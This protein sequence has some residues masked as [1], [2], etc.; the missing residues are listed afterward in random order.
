MLY[1]VGVVPCQLTKGENFIDNEFCH[2][3]VY[4]ASFPLEAYQV[5]EDEVCGMFRV[6]WE[7]FRRLLEGQSDTMAAKGIVVGERRVCSRVIGREE[8]V[9]HS[10]VYVKKIKEAFEQLISK[11]TARIM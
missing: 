11:K 5:Q 3:F 6:R 9:P 4:E 2:V 8:L 10:R 7:E 1:P